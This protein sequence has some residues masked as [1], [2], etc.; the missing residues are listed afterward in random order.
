MKSV[1]VILKF[2][3]KEYF[4]KKKIVK[5]VSLFVWG[6]YEEVIGILEVLLG[7]FDIFFILGYFVEI[8]FSILVYG[9]NLLK[10]YLFFI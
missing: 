2:N 8:F 10:F 4:G 3:S 7:W 1:Y 9:I 6:I 5:Y